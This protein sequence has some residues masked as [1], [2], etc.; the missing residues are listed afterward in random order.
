MPWNHLLARTSDPAVWLQ[1]LMHT[2]QAP[3]QGRTPGEM[4]EQQREK[5]A[6]IL[7]GSGLAGWGELKDWEQV[8]AGGLSERLAHR[9]SQELPRLVRELAQAM[10]LPGFDPVGALPGQAAEHIGWQKNLTAQ[11]CEIWKQRRMHAQPA[12]AAALSAFCSDVWTPRQPRINA[13]AAN[14]PE[15]ESVKAP[16]FFVASS[17]DGQQQGLNGWLRLWLWPCEGAR[18]AFLPSVPQRVQ[19][20][21]QSWTDGLA[22]AN[23]WIRRRLDGQGGDW[24]DHAL[25][26]DVYTNECAYTLLQGNS[27]SA[28]FALAGLWLARR[29]APVE[30]AQWLACLRRDDWL[31][32]RI[33][34]A[35]DDAADKTANDLQPVG[36]VEYKHPANWVLNQGGTHPKPSPLRVAH[37]QTYG[38]HE[39]IEPAPYP[40]ANAHSLLQALARDALDLSEPLHALL[41]A[42]QPALPRFSPPENDGLP[43]HLPKLE[44]DWQSPIADQAADQQWRSQVRAAAADTTPPTSLEAFALKRWATL[45]QDQHEGGSVNCLFVNLRLEE[46]SLPH[47]QAKPNGIYALDELLAQC[48]PDSA[49]PTAHMQALMIAG[50]PGGGKTWLLHRFEQACTER[51]LWQLQLQQLKQQDN[52][53]HLDVPLY[54]SLSGLPTNCQEDEQIVRWFRA[55][56][57]GGAEAPES[58]LKTR[59]HAPSNEPR[60]RLRI[61][62]DGLNEVK[63]TG[64]QERAERVQQV[65]RALWEHLRPGLPM[66]MGTRTHHRY[67]LNHNSATGQPFK[68]AIASLHPW[69]PGQIEAYLL[70]RW[71]S[72]EHASL[73][74]KAAWLRQEIEGS[75]AKG[76]RLHEVLSLPLYLRIQCE[77]LEAG[78]TRLLDSRAQLM[79]A[80]LWRNLH[81]EF[82]LKRDES[83]D[84]KDC[85]LFSEQECAIA[86]Q[87]HDHPNMDPPAFPRTGRLLQGLFALAWQM[88]LANGDKPAESRGTVALPLHDAKTTDSAISVAGVLSQLGW[89]G[90]DF[91]NWKQ[92]WLAMAQELG[93]L[94]VDRISQTARFTHQAYGEFLASQQLFWKPRHA[95]RRE[96]PLPQDWKEDE[97]DELARLLAPPALPRSCLEELDAQYAELA[98]LWQNVPQSLLDDWLENG[99]RLPKQTVREELSQLGW[100]DDDIQREISQLNAGGEA[101]ITEQG[102]DWVWNLR[103][104]GD[105]LHERGE[106]WRCNESPWHTQPFAWAWLVSSGWGDRKLWRFY[107]RHVFQELEQYF[108]STGSWKFLGFDA[109]LESFFPGPLDEI[110]LLALDSLPDSLPWL[111]EMLRAARHITPRFGETSHTPGQTGC[112]ALLSHALQQEAV[113]LNQR[114]ADNPQELRAWRREVAKLLLEVN[115]SADPELDQ[116]LHGPFSSGLGAHDLRHR[117][118]AGICL[119][120]Q[121]GLGSDAGDHLRYETVAIHTPNG[122][123]AQGVRLK[124]EHWC[125]IQP[126][127]QGE[128]DVAPFFMAR[129][130]VSIGEFRTFL[131]ADGALD[132]NAPW[133]LQGQLPGHSGAQEWLRKTLGLGLRT[134]VS[135]ISLAPWEAELGP[136]TSVSWYDANAYTHWASELYADW[137]ADMAQKLS[138]PLLTLRL[139]TEREWRIAMRGA[140]K[141]WLRRKD[142]KASLPLLFNHLG[143]AWM[144]LSPVGSFPASQAPSG[145]YDGLGNTWEWCANAPAFGEH[146]HCAAS[147]KNDDVRR[148]RCGGSCLAPALQ[149]VPD[150][151]DTLYPSNNDLETGFRLV[152]AEPL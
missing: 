65:V 79:S 148:A 11:G 31:R 74:P 118:R 75:E 26:W 83:Q 99:L 54:V 150:Y 95:G 68:V 129:Y 36:G 25:V 151:R 109:K 88:W 62:L 107:C 97:L 137:L 48:E 73:R 100:A 146:G 98:R 119:G 71:A 52:P 114:H 139:P 112:W 28:V 80:L 35:I 32:V 104:Y 12:D 9:P 3:L 110:A 81:R 138:I 56:V 133:W 24:Q 20:L 145:I 91:E 4:L 22:Q 45:A 2:L 149:C 7:Q 124:R 42:L 127:S 47:R 49:T 102:Q 90:Q 70:K 108:G 128:T 5:V 66:L 13:P 125:M 46:Q 142:R 58:R 39:P 53:C 120:E 61:I 63:V 113:K 126:K 1:E 51:L 21:A 64:T 89:P 86:E 101:V 29:H 117:L 34:A 60:I 82:I 30:W 141:V 140:D 121:G 33:T 41:G 37:G 131:R 69:D 147:L 84:R 135:H 116:S 105:L 67:S 77:L 23:A 87:F 38:D 123:Q 152:I 10:K 16:I 6:R 8:V 78:A 19:P 57:L 111:Q 15:A 94:T 76:R 130:P 144:H 92:Q 44:P 136:I 55:Q 40:Y 59:L 85:G 132:A 103:L 17:G 115:Q 93:W 72:E 122:Q 134:S 43:R 106:F 143:T 27:A 18:L 50:A 14:W 96:T